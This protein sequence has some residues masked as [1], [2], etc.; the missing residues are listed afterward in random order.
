MLQGFS[1]LLYNQ[2]ENHTGHG[3]PAQHVGRASLSL[4][5]YA[6][7]RIAENGLDIGLQAATNCYSHTTLPAS[8]RSLFRLAAFLGN[9]LLL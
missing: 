4:S 9:G 8:I 2:I 6:C 7:T 1:D 5:P 3:I